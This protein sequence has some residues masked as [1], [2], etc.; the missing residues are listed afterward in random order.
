[1]QHHYGLPLGGIISDPADESPAAGIIMEQQVEAPSSILG[2][3]APLQEL[4]KVG[5]RLG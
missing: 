4:N 5:W 2:T 3:H 1:M